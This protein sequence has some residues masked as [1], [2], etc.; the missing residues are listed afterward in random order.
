MSRSLRA[1]G[2]KLNEY[3]HIGFGRTVALLAGAWIETSNNID[4]LILFLSRSLRARGL[5]LQKL[6]MFANI[7]V[8][9][10]IHNFAGK[11]IAYKA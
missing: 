1:R 8:E 5:K 6:K 9:V 4:R 10:F 7:C 3:L 11:I 2:L